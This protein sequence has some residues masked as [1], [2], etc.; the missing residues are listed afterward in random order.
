MSYRFDVTCAVRSSRRVQV[1]AVVPLDSMI[2]HR[3]IRS[4]SDIDAEVMGALLGR[5]CGCWFLDYDYFAKVVS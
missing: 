1:P 3:G 4:L 5:L 2:T